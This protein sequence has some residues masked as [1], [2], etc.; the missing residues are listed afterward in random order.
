MPIFTD[1]TGEIH[2]DLKIIKDTGRGK[3]TCQCLKCGHTDEYGKSHLINNR[4]LCKQCG[5]Q[6]VN[7]TGEIHRTLKIIE[8]LG[9]GN[10]KCECL[11]CGH[12][13]SY[14]KNRVT[15]A[16]VNC[17]QCTSRIGKD[18][19]GKIYKNFE[20]T[21]EL[22]KGRV[23]AKCLKCEHPNNFNKYALQNEEAKCSNC[24][25]NIA[26]DHT[27]EIYRD[28]KIIK[29]LG[30]GQLLCK[31]LLC[32]RE[33]NYYKHEIVS[34]K[35]GN[36]KHCGVNRGVKITEKIIGNI[37][38]L[39]REYTGRDGKTYFKCKCNKC[40]EELLLTREEIVKYI[41]TKKA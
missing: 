38:I 21:K 37:T 14:I 13:D 12:I 33:D 40:N 25:T 11:R 35:S 4:L 36:C 15:D 30:K 16:R 26:S 9:K 32:G 18:D 8:E 17:K 23:E 10:V 31:C 24:G 2:R 3:V 29:E 20:I 27:G 28:L 6:R 34:K 5:T 39:N 22:G 41:C 7:K 19:T 1:R